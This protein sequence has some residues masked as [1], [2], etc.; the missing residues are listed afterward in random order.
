VRQLAGELNISAASLA[1]RALARLTRPEGGTDDVGAVAAEVLRRAAELETSAS[2]GLGRIEAESGEGPAEVRRALMGL[3]PGGAPAAEGPLIELI[4]RLLAIRAQT[5]NESL[6]TAL[7][8]AIATLRSVGRFFDTTPPVVAILSPQ[9]DALLT[10]APEG[11]LADTLAFTLR[12]GLFS[13]DGGHPGP[14]GHAAATQ[15]ILSRFR[16]FADA[17][18]SKTYGG[19]HL[20]ELRLLTGA[21]LKTIKARDPVAVLVPK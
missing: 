5:E 11:A 21:D 20:S 1:S 9:T 10:S 16:A 19:V 17:A 13:L 2:E 8:Q 12:G 7:A 3:E 6:K 4:A 18:Q 14:Y 15:R